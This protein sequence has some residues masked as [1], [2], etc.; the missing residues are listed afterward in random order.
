M[1]SPE[2]TPNGEYLQRLLRF[3]EE[4][5]QEKQSGDDTTAKHEEVWELYFELSKFLISLYEPR[6]IS[7]I[8]D[9]PA[10]LHQE[11][12]L[13]F[14]EEAESIYDQIDGFCDAV[15]TKNLSSRILDECRLSGNGVTIC[16][17]IAN[18]IPEEE[19]AA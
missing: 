8:R 13:S 4:L 11:A 19:H 2:L 17:W 9:M 1:K 15:I 3:H 5:Y 6:S 14:I 12:I 18:N 7:D 10:L 16:E